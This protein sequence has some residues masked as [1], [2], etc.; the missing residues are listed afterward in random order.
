MTHESADRECS[1]HHDID[2]DPLTM[3]VEVEG[4]QA[5]SRA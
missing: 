1:V 2:S 5:A 3:Y 4:E